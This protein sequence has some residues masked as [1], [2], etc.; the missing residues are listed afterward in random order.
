MTKRVTGVN[1]DFADFDEIDVDAE[2]AIS[3]YAEGTLTF[4]ELKIMIGADAARA[5]EKSVHGGT[6][7]E[8]LFDNPED[9]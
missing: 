3:E 7:F 6:D 2:D 8:N 5:V 9:Y 1:P 4:A